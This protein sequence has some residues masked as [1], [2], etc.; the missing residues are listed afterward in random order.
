MRLD[1]FLTKAFDIQSRNKAHELIKANKIKIDGAIITKPSFKVE[2]NHNI[3]ILEECFY[4]S[5]AAYKLK[6]F[7]DE[8]KNKN[9]ITI[10]M[11]ALKKIWNYLTWLEEQRIKAAIKTGSAG[12]LM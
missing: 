4:V 9:E 7:L 12:P 3:E 11:K 5:R 6:Y 2:E 8:L 1:L 10:I